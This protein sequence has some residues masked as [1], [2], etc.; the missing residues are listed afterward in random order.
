MKGV[1][2]KSESTYQICL[3][4]V[5]LQTKQKEPLLQEQVVAMQWISPN[6]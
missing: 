5:P 6:I 4:F 1:Y 3:R 2:I